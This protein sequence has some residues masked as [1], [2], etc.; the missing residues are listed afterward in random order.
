[1]TGAF[2]GH[3]MSPNGTQR[4]SSDDFNE[5]GSS[6]QST[7]TFRLRASRDETDEHGECLVADRGRRATRQVQLRTLGE[8]AHRPTP[9]VCL[10][11][12]AADP[13]LDGARGDVDLKSRLISPRHEPFAIPEPAEGRRPGDHGHS[14]HRAGPVPARAARS[15]PFLS[16]AST[17]ERG[18]AL[19]RTCRETRR[20]R[21][22]PGCRGVRGRW[23]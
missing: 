6:S 23:R 12:L 19:R 9:R 21:S 15:T 20:P 1:M 22:S 8:A 2:H 18:D 14:G 7:L 11:H 13:N 4:L 3:A 17:P 16:A 5:D 10:R